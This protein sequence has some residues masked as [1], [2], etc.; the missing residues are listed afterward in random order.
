MIH[1]HGGPFSDSATALAVWKGRH[2]MI[3]FA[4]PE[5]IKLAAE[6]CQSYCLDNGA[7]SAWRRGAKITVDKYYSWVESWVRH[8]GF[9]FAIIPDQIDGREADNN[10]LLEEWP[11]ERWQGCPVWHMHES[12]ARLRGLAREWPRIAL[13]SSGIYDQPGSERW[14][15]RM[16]SA[17]KA[18]CDP[19]GKP[20][21]R[22]HGLRMLNPALSHAYLWLLQTRRMFRAMSS[23]IRSGRAPMRR[24][25]NEFEG[26]SSWTELRPIT[27]ALLG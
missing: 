5:Q 2:A 14:W 25:R 3:S 16:G 11:F 4:R 27:A 20:R 19:S 8:P 13:G 12:L 15:L 22:L 23:W 6:V 26:S 21:T 1:Y 10:A 7:Y 9:D 17:M 18:C 24:L